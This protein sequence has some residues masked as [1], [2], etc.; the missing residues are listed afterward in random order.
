M[1]RSFVKLIETVT[2]CKNIASCLKFNYFLSEIRLKSFF[3]IRIKTTGWSHLKEIQ[4]NPESIFM[5]FFYA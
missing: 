4:S 2:F 5:L 1:G 3:F